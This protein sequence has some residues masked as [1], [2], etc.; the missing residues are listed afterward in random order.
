[1]DTTLYSAVIKA[2]GLVGRVERGHAKP[3]SRVL[4][5]DPVSRR[6]SL[7]YV[8][9]TRTTVD[10]GVIHGGIECWTKASFETGI[11]SRGPAVV[12]PGQSDGH[13]GTGRRGFPKDILIGQ[14]ID[15]RPIEP[16]SSPSPGVKKSR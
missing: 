3:A 4:I 8:P 12:K 11:P 1:M 13:S 7:V 9:Q 15:T 10:T 2:D 6:I 14:V 5:G 16:A